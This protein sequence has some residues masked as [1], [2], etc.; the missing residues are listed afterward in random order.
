MSSNRSEII[1]QATLFNGLWYHPPTSSEIFSCLNLLLTLSNTGTQQAKDG[2]P[3]WNP[4]WLVILSSITFIDVKILI[5]SLVWR[6]RKSPIKLLKFHRFAEQLA[7]NVS[8]N[9]DCIKSAKA[10]PFKYLIMI[11]HDTV[12]I[13]NPEPCWDDALSVVLSATSTSRIIANWYLEKVCCNLW[14]DSAKPFSIG[15]GLQGL[16]WNTF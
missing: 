9:Q 7:T 14:F 15:S 13:F 1:K 16:H 4:Q 2:F 11:E 3:I 5:S 10:E 6:N 8:I 12:V